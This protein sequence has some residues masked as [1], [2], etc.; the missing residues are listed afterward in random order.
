MGSIIIFI[1]LVLMFGLPGMLYLLG[2]C[3]GNVFGYKAIILCIMV[4]IA[5]EIYA[6]LIKKHN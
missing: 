4:I 5:I 1:V 2:A 3:L 6:N